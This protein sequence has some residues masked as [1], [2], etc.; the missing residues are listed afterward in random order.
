MSHLSLQ[1][2]SPDRLARVTL[3]RWTRKPDRALNGFAFDTR[4]LRAG[5]VFISLSCGARD[6]HEFIGRALEKG[7]SA[8]LVEVEQPA[9]IPQLVVPDTVLAIAAIG[10]DCRRSFHGP[11][12]GITG[13]CGKTS[14]KEMLRCLLGGDL[15]HATAGNWNNHIGVPMTLFGLNDRKHQFAVIEAGINQP[16]E[17]E[18]LGR[19]IEA[20]LCL[21]TN[22]GAAHLELLGSREGIAAEKSKIA[23][24]SKSGAP[25][26][27]PES[28]LRY[29][30]FTSI[31]DR[32]IVVS[33]F[34]VDV[35]EGI[36]GSAVYSLS[37]SEDGQRQ[38]IQLSYAGT[39]TVYELA[40]SSRGMAQ[41]AAL[42]LVSALK[43]G[44][45][46]SD[47]RT[48][49]QVWRPGETRGHLFE[50]GH[51][52]V[53]GDHYNANPDSLVDALSAFD[54][55]APKELARCYVLGVMNELG[56]QAEALHEECG[57]A[58]QLRSGDRAIFIGPSPMVAAF[59][60]GALA[61]GAN[62]AQIESAETAK[63][64]KRIVAEFQGALFLKG[65]RSYQ[66]ESL[67]TGPT[68]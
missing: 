47:L 39:N 18:A 51:Q 45:S 66:L 21:L 43:L 60:R 42:A 26:I 38:Q 16:G 33:E 10:F 22:I 59:G 48:R 67:L 55:V 61:A 4:Q 28:A 12:I 29:E 5:D 63:A 62:L 14:T 2:F 23:E 52:L 37:D 57:A 8:C 24:F 13:S 49:L 46:P 41:N 58:L 36:H 27:L 64:V 30:A 19:M 3:G 68:K 35:P 32:C 50:S 20:D 56:V 34:G 65:S 25:L 54:R 7:A 44:H 17:M 31:K 11:V 15:V 53:Y 6:G 9:H 40:S 1:E